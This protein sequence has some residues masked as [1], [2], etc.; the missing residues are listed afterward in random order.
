MPAPFRAPAPHVQAATARPAA[1]ARLASPPHPPLPSGAVQRKPAPL[2]RT[3]PLP[4]ARG[5]LQLSAFNYASVN[6]N[7]PYASSHLPG[8]S[9]DEFGDYLGQ[10]EKLRSSQPKPVI[11]IPPRIQIA[12]SQEHLDTFHKKADEI[13]EKDAANYVLVRAT[14]NGKEPKPDSSPDSELESAITLPSSTN[15][16]RDSVADGEVQPLIRC[17]KAFRSHLQKSENQSSDQN[18]ALALAGSH[19]AC[20]GCKERI[21]RFVQFWAQA[22]DTVM[23]KG[24]TARLRLTYRYHV[25]Y[26]GFPRGWGLNYYGWSEDDYPAPFLHTI[27]ASVRGE[28]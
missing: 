6:P 26:K 21:D 18:F 14:V 1:P 13:T 16:V 19:G 4:G 12:P 2:P 5:V 7:D 25:P 10:Q 9:W 23:Q 22:A 15:A 11:V 17:L 27:E 24:A 28:N 8:F 20:D 3:I